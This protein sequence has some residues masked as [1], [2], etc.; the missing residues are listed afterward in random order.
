MIYATAISFNKNDDKK[1][2]TIVRI[3]LESDKNETWKI[4]DK[5]INGWFKKEIIHGWLKN[6]ADEGF[7]IV[8][9][10]DPNPELEA[11]ENKS[12]KYVRS[13]RNNSVKDNLLNLPSYSEKE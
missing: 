12:V 7:K 3:K 11:V 5:P 8:V 10:I 2:E 1:L 9:N 4:K 13:S 6:K